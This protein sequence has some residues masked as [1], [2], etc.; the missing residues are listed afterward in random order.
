MTS[1]R[2]LV[3]EDAEVYRSGIVAILGSAPD[4]EVVGEA[5]DGEAALALAARVR[6]DVAL[7]DL[8][9]PALGGVET[10][11]RLAI[12]LPACR[13]V[14]LTHFD[15]DGL[16]FDALRAGAAGY[17]LKDLTAE[18]VIAAVRHVAQGESV[19]APSVT[20]RVLAEFV[21]LPPSAPPD[22]PDLSPREREVLR[23]IGRGASN[24][25]IAAAL[26]LAEGTVKNHVT[27][28]IEKLG[29]EGRTQAA[30]RARALDLG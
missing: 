29:V 24:K 16:I 27:R 23:L 1:I 6:P 26:H 21:R 18:A 20:S 8:R 11:R 17:L 7:V 4:I 12:Q 22:A 3:A 2:V 19:L 15:E 10:I 9:M 28:V 5:A 14:V 25:E 30:L 13:C